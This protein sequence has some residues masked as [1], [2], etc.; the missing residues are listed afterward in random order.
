MEA[1]SLKEL[2]FW[3]SNFVLLSIS[4]KILNVLYA[5]KLLYITAVSFVHAVII[6]YIRN[7]PDFLKRTL[8]I[9][10]NL[11]M[12]GLVQNAAVIFFHFLN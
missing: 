2:V 4:L 5:K 7:V 3:C 11:R 6:L 8:L 9:L 1:I 10:K 12:N